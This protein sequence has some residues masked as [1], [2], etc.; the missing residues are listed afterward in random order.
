MT[1]TAHVYLTNSEQYIQGHEPYTYVS[2]SNFSEA[3]PGWLHLGSVEV[4]M[5]ELPEVNTL[6]EEALAGI[7][8]EEAAAR[9]LHEQAMQVLEG[10]RQ[11]LLAL[12]HEVIPDE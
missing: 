10:R 5:P 7:K 2:E 12:P 8:A 4:P 1:L 3:P 11:R 9:V 6:R